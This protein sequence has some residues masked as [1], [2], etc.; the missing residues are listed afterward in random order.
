M[1]LVDT[2]RPTTTQTPATHTQGLTPP[3]S[4]PSTNPLARDYL[5]YSQSPEATTQAR[6][7]VLGIGGVEVAGLPN[8]VRW[9]ANALGRSID[10]VARGRLGGHIRN[11]T[12]RLSSLPGKSIFKKPGEVPQLLTK[13]LGEARDAALKHGDDLAAGKTVTSGKTTVVQQGNRLAVTTDMGK[14]IGREGETALRTV[15]GKA[16]NIVTAYPVRTAAA[17]AFFGVTGLPAGQAQAMYSR[18]DDRV[19]QT[20]ERLQSISQSENK[21]NLLNEVLGVLDPTGILYAQPANKGEQAW[22]ELRNQ[23]QAAVRDIESGLGRSLSSR[24]RAT[25]ERRFTDAV[26]GAGVV[27]GG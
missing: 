25:F 7:D 22:V 16:G 4:T 15:V 11:H 17:G 6:Q 12:Q 3:N 10:D 20:A 9:G 13:S 27:S 26:Q 19:A 14:P 5:A 23:S 1:T 2:S 24:E 21:P 18:F 8:L